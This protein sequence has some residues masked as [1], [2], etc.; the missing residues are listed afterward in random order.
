MRAFAFSCLACSCFAASPVLGQQDALQS[1]IL[2]Q[3][4]AFKSDDFPTA[5]SFA[6]PVIRGI[7]GTPENFGAMVQ[8][9]YPMVYR[10]AE[11]RMLDQRQV[12]GLTVQRVLVTDA[13]GRSHVLDYQMVETPDGWLIN[14]V[15]LVPSGGIG[16]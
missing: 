6:S 10:P 2:N 3:L 1:T 9:G 4:D 7:F 5:F 8:Q 11:V 16:V 13:Q 12:G 14:G 15:T